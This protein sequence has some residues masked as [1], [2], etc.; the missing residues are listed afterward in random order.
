[1][2]IL[3]HHWLSSTALAGV[4]GILALMSTDTDART[5]LL[6]TAILTAL[7]LLTAALRAV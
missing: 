5:Q 6:S 1:V 2:R 4:T 7:I 3:G